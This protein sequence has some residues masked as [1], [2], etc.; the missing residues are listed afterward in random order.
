MSVTILKSVGTWQAARGQERN[1][2]PHTP[3]RGRVITGLLTGED[4]DPPIVVE[5][6]PRR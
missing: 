4:P 6:R 1:P 3:L 5:P 2:D